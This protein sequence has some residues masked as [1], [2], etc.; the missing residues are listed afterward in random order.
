MLFAMQKTDFH[1]LE[2]F[3]AEQGMLELH[4]QESLV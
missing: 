4:A 2:L 3:V 1:V